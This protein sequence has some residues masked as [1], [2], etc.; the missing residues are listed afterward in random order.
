MDN[1]YSNNQNDG[2]FSNNN[3]DGYNNS[4]AYANGNNN[5]GAYNYQYAPQ[6]GY[7]Q[8]FE[9]PVTMGEW[10]VSMLLMLIPCVN[11]VL[12]FVWAFS[13]SEKKSKSNFFKASLIMTAIAIVLEFI[14]VSVLM[15]TFA[16]AF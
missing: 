13:S 11:I 2:M 10:L 15:A 4:A 16:A 5:A 14:L 12:M 8:E 6:G 3:A 1:N 9:P 7:E